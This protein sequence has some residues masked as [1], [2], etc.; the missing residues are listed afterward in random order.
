MKRLTIALAMVLFAVGAAAAHDGCHAN[1]STYS[2]G[3]VMEDKGLVCSC[4]ADGN[5]EWV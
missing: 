4:D 5:C 3:W 2:D 1:G